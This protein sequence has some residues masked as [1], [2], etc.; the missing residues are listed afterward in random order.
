MQI[1]YTVT[2][3]ELDLVIN[4]F[5]SLRLHVVQAFEAIFCVEQGVYLRTITLRFLLGDYVSYFHP[6]RKLTCLKM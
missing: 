1:I 6:S 5:G 3:R 2:A 4:A